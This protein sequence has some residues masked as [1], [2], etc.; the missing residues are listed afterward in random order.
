MAG[1]KSRRRKRRVGALGVLLGLLLTLGVAALMVFGLY[2]VGSSR[3]APESQ[4]PAAPAVTTP[5]SVFRTGETVEN[6]A[7][8]IAEAPAAR[9]L[10]VEEFGFDEIVSD[11][12]GLFVAKILGKRYVGYIAVIDDPLRLT[13]GRCPYF[14]DTAYGRSVQQ[15]VEEH[16]AVL[17]VNGGG[18]SDVGG[19]GRG[20][21]PTGNVIIDGQI[22]WNGYEGTVGMD[23]SGKLHVGNYNYTDCVNLGLQ[24]AVSYGPTL[25]TDGV[26]TAD[27]DT[28]HQEPRTALGQ[29]EDGSIVIVVLQGRQL[30]ALGVT[31]RQ[32]AE[33][34]LG[35]GCV[36]A[37]N[38]DGGASSD[39]FFRGEYLNVCNTSGGPRPIPTSVLVMPPRET[40]G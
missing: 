37:G 23:A 29:R 11:E 17:G 18:F 19:V 9:D 34:M 30:Q 13:V 16:G 31:E 8:P 20:G 10:Q 38:L 6:P 27:L 3:P 2:M 12:D 14:G 39:I 5:V 21:L 25:V 22:L 40:E 32:L 28:R 36:N 33:I 1:G 4:L 26:M 15:M 7:P 24:W 35:Y